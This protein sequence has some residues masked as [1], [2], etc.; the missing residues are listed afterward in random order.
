MLEELTAGGAERHEPL[1]KAMTQVVKRCARYLLRWEPTGS[2]LV[3]L[4]TGQKIRF[5]RAGVHDEPI[6]RLHNYRVLAK[7]LRRGAIGFAEA[8][9]DG[10]IECTDLTALFR[11][12]VRNRDKLQRTSR[13]LFKVRIADR[14]AHLARRNSRL[15]SRRN[16]I[17]HY[18][19]GNDFFKLWLDSEMNYSSGLYVGGAGSLED[20]QRAKLDL[21][22]DMLGLSDKSHILEIG[23]GWGAFAR[24][25]AQR[26]GVRV[27]GVTLSRE[28]LQHACEQA[29][30]LG[31]GA[32]CSFR[33]QDYR[34]VSDRFDHIVSVEMIE[35]VGK[36]YW[37]T[38]FR[39][40]NDRLKPGGTAVLQAITIDDTRYD[41]YRRST[42]FI[43]RYIFPGG[44]LPSRAAIE[45]QAEKAGFTLER[46]EQFGPCYARTL[47]EWQN[48]F[49]AAWAEI[50]ELGFDQRFR[51]LWRYYLCYCEAGFLE[52]VLAVGLYR[53]RKP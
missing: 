15:G 4:P 29:A 25:A 1:T 22:L 43:Q 3:E 38:Y 51:R 28:Q 27:T 39:I 37:P 50:A 18:D 6:L 11:F 42:D 40:L 23:C 49:Q 33:L 45:S 5:G 13:G 26:Y 44:M 19:L 24:L 32:N 52:G 20:A 9:I 7:T 8:F 31:L 10:D 35:A 30:R 34:D 47:W 48:R 17:E 14:I 41:R 46:V 53:L 12:F 2:V 36:E 16:I 21:I